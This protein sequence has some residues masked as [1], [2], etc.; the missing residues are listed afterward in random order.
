MT[1]TIDALMSEMPQPNDHD[2]PMLDQ[3]LKPRR[4]R[5]TFLD[6]WIQDQ[7][8]NPAS[9]SHSTDESHSSCNPYLAYPQ[10][11]RTSSNPING[12]NNLGEQC[13]AGNDQHRSA[14]EVRRLFI[15]FYSILIFTHF[16]ASTFYRAFTNT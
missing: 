4:R 6:R 9:P 5:S 8:S 3:F 1:T 16:T 7:Q 15:S 10:L 2:V 13:P 14:L 12:N 11:S